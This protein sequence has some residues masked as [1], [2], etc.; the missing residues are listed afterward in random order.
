MST[1]GELFREFIE[2][3]KKPPLESNDFRFYQALSFRLPMFLNEN[4]RLLS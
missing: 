1:L 3:E 2:R 4:I